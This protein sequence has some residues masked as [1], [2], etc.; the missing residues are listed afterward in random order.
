VYHLDIESVGPNFPEQ[1]Q[2]EDF[3]DDWLV[4]LNLLTVKRLSHT[5]FNTFDRIFPLDHYLPNTLP[6]VVGN[7]FNYDIESYLV[8]SFMAR[9][10]LGENAFERYYYNKDKLRSIG[11]IRA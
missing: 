4:T 11:V 6:T 7:C 9:G 8:L 1:I 3:S 5:Y 2:T 10:C